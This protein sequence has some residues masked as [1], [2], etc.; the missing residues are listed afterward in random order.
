MMTASAPAASAFCAFSAN[1][2]APRWMSAM[3][4]SA[5]RSTP[6]K[7]SGSQPLVDVEG[8]SSARSTPV[9]GPVTSPAPLPVYAPV[10]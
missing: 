9:T 6:L 7:S 5:L 1:V 2:Q 8:S 3:S 10:S 4:F